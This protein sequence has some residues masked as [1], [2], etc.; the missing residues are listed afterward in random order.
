MYEFCCVSCSST[1]EVTRLC[2]SACRFRPS[3]HLPCRPCERRTTCGVSLLLILTLI[4][5]AVLSQQSSIGCQDSRHDMMQ[6]PGHSDHLWETCLPC[7]SMLRFRLQAHSSEPADQPCAS[8]PLP[9]S[10][11]NTLPEIRQMFS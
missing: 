9:C 5:R 8:L 3:S 4:Q 2:G 10:L 11:A 7:V 1:C 6:L